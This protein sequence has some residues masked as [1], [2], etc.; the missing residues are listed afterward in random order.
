MYVYA[1]MLK[2]MQILGSS[3]GFV[4]HRLKT[5][6]N[7]GFSLVSIS[8]K[9]SP[10]SPSRTPI[11]TSLM[12]PYFSARKTRCVR[13]FRVTRARSE[14]NPD[15]TSSSSSPSSSSVTFKSTDEHDLC[16][17]GEENVTPRKVR[18]SPQLDKV[19]E[20]FAVQELDSNNKGSSYTLIKSKRGVATQGMGVVEANHSTMELGDKQQHGNEDAEAGQCDLSTS[21]FVRRIDVVEP[22]RSFAVLRFKSFDG[23]SDPTLIDGKLT[24]P[25]PRSLLDSS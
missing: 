25:L 16:G 23:C 14:S 17:E 10:F 3:S 4:S 1:N 6:G 2:A 12:T 8:T 20:E 15:V 22:P 21:P 13:E 24:R 5:Y 11:H 9:P 19:L 7:C 18:A